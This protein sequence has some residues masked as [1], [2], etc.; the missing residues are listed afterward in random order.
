[1]HEVHNNILANVHVSSHLSSLDSNYLS[2]LTVYTGCM[3]DKGL[4]VGIGCMCCSMSGA[5]NSFNSLLTVINL[6][7]L[8]VKIRN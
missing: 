2:I 1:M 5:P 4:D 3:L 6:T 8:R 7:K